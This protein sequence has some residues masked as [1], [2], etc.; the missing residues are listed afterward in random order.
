MYFADTFKGVV[1]AGKADT[2]YK[3]GEHANTSQEIVT[4]LLKRLDIKDY[5]LLVGIFPDDFKNFS[6]GAIKICHIDV[7]TYLSA[8][9]IV[10][11]IWPR[12]IKGGV[13]IFDDYG[14]FGCE[15][16]TK[17]VNELKLPDA[18]FVHNLNGHALLIKK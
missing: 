13:I 10:N 3:G 14:F 15:G 17:Y 18:R 12:V 7:D 5:Q 9:E 4:E 11:F 16:V 2:L 8:K 6:S 1:K